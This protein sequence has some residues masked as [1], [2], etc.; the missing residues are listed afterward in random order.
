MA[1]EA[2]MQKVRLGPLIALRKSGGAVRGIEVE[3]VIRKLTSWIIVEQ[4]GDVV[5]GAISLCRYASST[6]EGCECICHALF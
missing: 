4:L 6:R 3:D 2:S 1:P 5:M